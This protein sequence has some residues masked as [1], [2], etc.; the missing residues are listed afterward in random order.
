[1]NNARRKV[2][3]YSFLAQ[4]FIKKSIFRLSHKFPVMSKWYVNHFPAI[5]L[6]QTMNAWEYSISFSSE[7]LVVLIVLIVSLLNV[8]IFNPFSSSFT[9]Q[10][11]SIAAAV[12]QNH[13]DLNKQLAAK[14][15]TIST[16][17]ESKNGFISQVYADNTHVLGSTDHV[18][19]LQVE[20]EIE[21]NG[22]SKANP[23]SIKKLVSRQ[24]V[25]HE[26]VSNDTVYSIAKKY[27]VSTK[28]IMETNGLP[29]HSLKSGWFLVIPPVDG[30]V[31]QITNPNVTL[32][33]VA[34]K[35]SADINKVISYNGLEGE[36]DMVELNDYLIVPDGKT[37]EIPKPV[38]SQPKA[39][40][41]KTD[42]FKPSVPRVTRIAGNHKFAAGYCTDYVAKKVSGVGWGGNANMWIANSKAY[43]ATVNRTP[44]AGSILVT[45]ENSRYGHV[46]YIEKVEGSKVYISEW[47]YSGLYKTTYRTLDISDS[48]I[49]GIIH[50]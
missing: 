44:K 50:P 34:D 24:V 14:H 29:D 7:V 33:D 25:I 4:Y 39:E 32:A 35:Y 12:L 21:D 42:K 18:E 37:P 11:H 43:G 45:N 30:L 27:N 23:D 49:K 15:N 5:R 2:R 6:G 13:Q 26:T 1:M 9:N 8:V 17:V 20:N 36:E 41:K 31:I 47:N 40:P 38:E 48:K 22:I 28:T 46:A 3:T 19:P 10:D 16:K